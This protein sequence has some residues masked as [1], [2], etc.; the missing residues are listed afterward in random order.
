[1]SQTLQE[2][3]LREDLSDLS[4]EIWSDWMKYIFSVCVN[5]GENGSL[6]IPESYVLHWKRQIRTPYGE[7]TEK[8]KDGDREQADKIL[9][10]SEKHLKNQKPNRLK[11]ISDTF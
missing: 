11:M 8:E 6:T 1:M 9:K 10:V 4:H 2:Q 3:D 7:L 5:E